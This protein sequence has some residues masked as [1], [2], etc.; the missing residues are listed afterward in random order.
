MLLAV[1][2]QTGP[3][4]VETVVPALHEGAAWAATVLVCAAPG[5]AEVP[6]E[7]TISPATR[8]TTAANATIGSRFVPRD[9]AVLNLIRI[10][11]KLPGA[12]V[13]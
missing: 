3:V 13:R 5:V 9:H 2:P 4:L 6:A 8:A 10:I 11:A 1:R 7:A 12:A